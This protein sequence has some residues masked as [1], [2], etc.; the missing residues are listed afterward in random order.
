MTNSKSI[1]ASAFEPIIAVNGVIGAGVSPLD[2]GFN[3]GDGLFETVRLDSNGGRAHLP[4][5]PLHRRRL[6]RSCGRL[7]ISL[8]PQRLDSAVEQLLQQAVSHNVEQGVVKIVVSRG[9]GGRGYL[10]PE[11]MLATLCVGLYPVAVHPLANVEE[12]IHL[13]LCQ[14]RLSSNLSLAGMKHLS[15][16]EYVLA[17][18]EWRDKKLAEGVLLDAV[19]NV[20]EGT[21]SN[22]FAVLEGKLLTP[23]LLGCGVA[24]VMRR[25]IL[26]VLAPKL[27][28]VVLESDISLA[29]LEAADEVFT[30]NSVCGIWPVLSL[31]GPGLKCGWLRGA[32][33]MRLQAELDT[34]LLEFAR[35]R[36]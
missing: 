10:A 26:D 11:S 24:G 36:T 9:V 18:S 31:S 28:V 14:Q 16:L 2:R 7:L 22:V 30:C 25:L 1:S 15:K 20:V 8:D 12:G 5:W 32:L 23:A 33:T 35:A 34:H 3:Y 27:G 29:E 19:G 17:R 4:L 21:F 13:H 6:L